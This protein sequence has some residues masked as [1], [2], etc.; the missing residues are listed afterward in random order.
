MGAYI[1]VCENFKKCISQL[2]LSP[3]WRVVHPVNFTLFDCFL[4]PQ[5]SRGR[6]GPP[7]C[8][9]WEGWLTQKLLPCASC[10]RWRMVAQSTSLPLPSS[11][12]V[13]AGSS[14]WWTARR[15][16]EPAARSLWEQMHN[17]HIKQSEQKTLPLLFNVHIPA[18]CRCVWLISATVSVRWPGVSSS[19]LPVLCLQL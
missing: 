19:I 4:S 11:S 3:P 2:P 12:M 14:L 18:P 8:S 13:P 17:R 10:L 16:P 15:P 9:F 1:C 5:A 6:T 7:W